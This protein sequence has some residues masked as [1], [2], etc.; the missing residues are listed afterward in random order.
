MHDLQISKVPP[1][2]SRV[3]LGQPAAPD[4]HGSPSGVPGQRPRIDIA[5]AGGLG[6]VLVWIISLWWVHDLSH[7]E[8]PN[9]WVEF[10]GPRATL[11]AILVASVVIHEL[12]HAAILLNAGFA[13]K[14]RFSPLYGYCSALDGNQEAVRLD[15]SDAQLSPNR[16]LAVYLAGPAAN[17][18]VAALSA[19]ALNTLDVSD[20]GWASQVLHQLLWLNTV[21]AVFNL[22][23]IVPLDGGE[24]ADNLF[25]R[26]AAPVPR[27]A[28][29]VGLAAIGVGAS[30][31]VVWSLALRCITHGFGVALVLCI[32][33]WCL[34]TLIGLAC[35]IEAS[36]LPPD[37]TS[38]GRRSVMVAA[39][40]S[41]AAGMVLGHLLLVP[42]IVG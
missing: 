42:A 41:A 15:G 30:A 31:A 14:V 40:T 9:D 17:F 27:T 1:A 37:A 23:P 6:G 38:F 21:F 8:R 11:L 10:V 4:V 19:V 35:L 33:A 18:A 20:G 22:L 29:R 2:E 25:R 34:I 36:E 28:T 13:A 3:A 39:L 24:A 32:S 26:I 12:A 16:L 7:P 5:P